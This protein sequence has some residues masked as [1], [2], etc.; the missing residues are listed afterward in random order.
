MCI[1]TFVIS[2][3]ISAIGTRVRIHI[4]IRTQLIIII[5]IVQSV[6]CNLRVTHFTYGR[7]YFPRRRRRRRSR[8]RRRR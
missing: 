3:A 4:Y 5:I 6:T 2:P 1:N 8:R 7:D